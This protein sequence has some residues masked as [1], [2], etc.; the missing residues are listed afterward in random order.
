MVCF[1]AV[2]SYSHERGMIQTAHMDP[3]LGDLVAAAGA[4][5][6][7]AAVCDKHVSG[8]YPGPRWRRKSSYNASLSAIQVRTYIDP[9][10]RV[11]ILPLRRRS[12]MAPISLPRLHTQRCYFLPAFVACSHAFQWAITSA[13]QHAWEQH[14]LFSRPCLLRSMAAWP[15]QDSV[16]RTE[17]AA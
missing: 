8:R 12:L 4:A 9:R 14:R 2:E 16:T 15:S 3:E 10:S 13:I 1:E 6:N 5:V 11:K 17:N 7:N